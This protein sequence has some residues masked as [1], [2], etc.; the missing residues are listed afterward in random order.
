MSDFTI[1][2]G[3]INGLLLARELADSGASICLLDQG[4]F[5]QEAS[6]AGGGIISPLYP[7]RY[8]PAITALASWAQDFYPQLSHRLLEETGIDPE[9]QQSGLLMLAAEDSEQ[10]LAWAK[11]NDKDIEPVAGDFLMSREPVLSREFSSGLWM[12]AVAN[13][14]NPRLIRALVASLSKASN[15]SLVEQCKV[16]ELITTGDRVSALRFAE[17]SS[18]QSIE[19]KQLVITAGAWSGEI[20][21][22][23]ASAIRVEPVKGQMLLFKLPQKMTRSIILHRGRYLIPRIDGH[24]LVGSTLEYNGFDKQSTEEAR[25]SLLKSAFQM[26]PCLQEYPVVAQ[27]AGLRPGAPEGVPYI[28]KVEGLENLYLNAGQFRNGLV[29][30]PA[31]ARLMAD[32]LLERDTI[33]DPEPYRLNR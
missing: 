4:Y 10:A 8:K 9:L 24:L 17:P 12:P 30:A 16:E 21:K 32:L 22:A 31:S 1:V 23:H 3:G 15:V 26:M 11:S 28:G 27:W 25:H 6:W 19:V 18:P 14:R 7:W 13:V 33:V 2:G 20:L 5:G 29:L